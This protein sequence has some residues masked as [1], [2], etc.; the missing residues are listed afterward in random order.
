MIEADDCRVNGTLIST[1]VV[2]WATN[3]VDEKSYLGKYNMSS[4]G[5]DF[6]FSA[7]HTL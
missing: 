5:T 1:S 3:N 4:Q 2:Y 7:E 6:C